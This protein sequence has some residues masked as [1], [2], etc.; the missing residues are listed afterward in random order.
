MCVVCGV[1]CVGC[2]VCGF[3]WSEVVGSGFVVSG[4]CGVGVCGVWA[5]VLTTEKC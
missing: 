4:V 3:V 5:H 1:L 2:G